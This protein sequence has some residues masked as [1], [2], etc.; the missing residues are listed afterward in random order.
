MLEKLREK[1][2][3]FPL[4]PGVYVMRSQDGEVLYA[5]KA[6]LLKKR[7]SSYF[8]SRNCVKNNALLEKTADIEYIECDNEAQAL[9]LEAALIKEKHP[10]YNISLRDDKSYPYVEITSQEFPRV[11]VSRPKGELKGMFFGPYPKVKLLKSALNMIRRIFPYCSCKGKPR[12]T[13]LFF[14]LRLCPAPCVKR[15][16]AAEYRENIEGI[17]RILRG[18]RKELIDSLEKKMRFLAEQKKF[19]EAARTRDKIRALQNLYKGKEYGHEIICLKDILRLPSLPILI[20]AIDISSLGGE[21]PAASVVVFKGGMPD[22]S[23]YRRFLIKGVQ[24]IDD[25]AMIK[26]VVRRRYLRLIKENKKLP[27]LV[28]IDGGKGHVN[29]AKKELVKLGADVPVIGIA[30]R[31]EEVWFPQSQCPLII[32]KDNPCLH[33]IQRIRDEAHRFAHKYH[34]VRRKKRM[35]G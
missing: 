32:S 19:E 27:D 3:N 24:N 10:K 31:N 30:K 5:G 17:R 13:C 33:V 11:L 9:I 2:K 14:H 23:N 6:A 21:S 8:S 7:V 4:C 22:K 29:K 34:L 25:Y 16:S 20:E 15:V 35:M 28:I 26:E 18:E 12:Q 1:V